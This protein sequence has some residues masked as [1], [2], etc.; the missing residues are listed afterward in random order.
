MRPTNLSPLYCVSVLALFLAKPAYAQ[1]DPSDETEAR[2]FEKVTVTATRREESIQ[3]VPVSVARVDQELIAETASVDLADVSRYVPNFEFSDAS[4]LP[5]LYIRGIG[6]GTTHSIE[7]SVGRFV[8]D[9][10]TGRAAINFH[11]LMDVASVEVL[12]GPQGTLFGKNTLAGALIINTKDPTDTLEFGATANVGQYSTTG[13]T[14]QAE[15]YVSGP[16]ADSLSARAVVYY[17]DRDGYIDNLDEGPDGGTREDIG[18]RLKLR[19]DIASDLVANLKLERM[20]YDEEGLTPS[21]TIF[22]ALPGFL[23]TDNPNPAIDANPAY[24]FEPNWTSFYDCTIA[25]PVTGT[26]CPGRDQTM[27]NITFDLERDF[28]G[29][30]TLT[31]ISAYQEVDYEHRFSQVDGGVGGSSV[32]FSRDEAYAGLTQEL[33]FAS[34]TYD[35]FDYIVGAYFETSEITRLQRDDT[36][37]QFFAPPAPGFPST[38]NEDWSQETETLAGFGQFRYNFTDQWTAIIGGRWSNETKDFNLVRR[39]VAYGADPRDPATPLLL[40]P[41][42]REP[43]G[44]EIDFTDSREE[45]KFTPSLTLRYEPNADLMVYASVSQGH[46]TGGFSDRPQLD[47]EFDEELN[48][49]YEIGSK[50]TGLDGRLRANLTLFSMQIEDLQVARTLPGAVSVNFEVQN[51]AEAV[52]QG[53]ESEI[54]LNLDNGVEIGG[55][56]AF[57]Q[58]EYEDFPGANTAPCPAVGGRVETNAGGVDLCNYEGNPLIFA[59]EHKGTVFASYETDTLPGRWS[60][61]A[62]ADASYSSEYYTENNYY[63]NLKQDAYWLYN[64]S[65]ALRSPD[66]R[67]TVRLYGKN[68]SD[69]YVLAWGLEAGPSRFVAP[70]PP[71]QIGLQL[72]YRY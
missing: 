30:G 21:E 13:T 9:V 35:K 57:T 55:N 60:F 66:G 71:R 18:A 44:E 31:A 10:Y 37:V 52:S 58:A 47:P 54:V 50:F 69:E 8:D 56:Y 3:D 26:F 6:S 22:S 59:P 38:F 23:F 41:A 33:R 1:E 34:E 17:S 72:S 24:D 62:R 20:D 25:Y 45:S 2:T 12:R 4:I 28:E 42:T 53:L 19:W 48:T 11:P 49:T 36:N 67:Y 32:R 46:K 63:E 15:T 43:V 39:E 40:D 14:R 65:L 68:L 7:Q 27:H 64:A 16:L 61:S 70:N 5:N 29:L 51:A